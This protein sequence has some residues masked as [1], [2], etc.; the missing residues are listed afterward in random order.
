MRI[1]IALLS[2]VLN[3]HLLIAIFGLTGGV[4]FQHDPPLKGP[5]WQ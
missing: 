4:L 1:E 3:L 5:D 2:G